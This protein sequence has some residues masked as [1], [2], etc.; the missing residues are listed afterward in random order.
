MK[1]ISFCLWGDN[2]KY[3]EGAIKNAQL[4]PEIYPGWK[5]RFYVG[6]SVPSIVL[7]RLEMNENTE[8]VRM[9]EWGNWKS[10]YWRFYPAAEEDVEVMISRDTDCRLNVREKEAVDEWLKSDRGFHIMRDHPYHA[11]P[12]LGGMWGAKRNCLPNMKEL[13]EGWAQK[14]AYGTDYEFFANVVMPLIQEDIFVHD[15]FF[16]GRRNP[17]PHPLAALQGC[18]SHD[19][20]LP[21]A[22]LEFVGEV[23][24]HEDNTVPEHTTVLKNYLKEH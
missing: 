15:E 11:F 22:G 13:I 9:P 2:P 5:C 4:A 10:M 23:Y 17:T 14:D 19:F 18:E 3:T 8:V 7:M 21:R 16:N 24:D 12:V 6:Q 1:L 20:P